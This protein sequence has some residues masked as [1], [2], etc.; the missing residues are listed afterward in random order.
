MNT[1]STAQQQCSCE[2]LCNRLPPHKSVTSRT[3]R[4]AK[5]K[6]NVGGN[7]AGLSPLVELTYLSLPY[8]NVDGNV[9]GLAP[10]VRLTSVRWEVDAPRERRSGNED[11]DMAI[12][13]EVFY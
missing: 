7:V 10:L 5:R 12:G 2:P 1:R 11:L 13:K 3:A 6:T 9:A 8:T 4:S